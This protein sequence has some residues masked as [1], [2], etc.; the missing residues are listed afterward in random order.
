MITRR[1]RSSLLEKTLV[2]KS[3][4]RRSLNWAN[5]YKSSHPKDF[6]GKGVLKI[7]LLKMEGKFTVSPVTSTNVR[8]KF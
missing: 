8:I 5:F 4:A 1:V 7:C 2:T 3:G 6:L